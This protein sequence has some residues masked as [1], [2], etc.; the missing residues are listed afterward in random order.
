MA[1]ARRHRDI[2]RSSVLVRRSTSSCAVGE[3]L[4]KCATVKPTT[5]QVAVVLGSHCAA[6]AGLE[7]MMDDVCYSWEERDDGTDVCVEKSGRT[8]AV[9]ALGITQKPSINASLMLH[10]TT[11]NRGGN[12][13][14]VH[15]TDRSRLGCEVYVHAQD[16][17]LLDC[18]AS[19]GQSRT[20]SN[21]RQCNNEFMMLQATEI[22]ELKTTKSINGL[23]CPVVYGPETTKSINGLT[24]PVVHGPETH[25]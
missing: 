5:T 8:D 6:D 16:G 15:D 17:S 11:N 25:Q 4:T 18:G 10:S 2:R 19:D 9:G 12:H 14:G 3:C 23:T 20:P 7:A 13:H 24:C 21:S 1:R 22:Y